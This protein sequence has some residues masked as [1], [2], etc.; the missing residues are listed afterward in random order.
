MDRDFTFSVYERLCTTLLENSFN[1]ITINDFIV[2]K[3][4]IKNAAIIR[5][6][7]DRKPN[8]ALKMARLENQLG[9]V[10]TYY[11]RTTKEVFIPEIISEISKLN[12]EIGYHYEVLALNNGNK[13]KAIKQ[14][15]EEL[16]LL[17]EI[18]KI[19]TIC[20]HGSPLSN[21][22]DSDMWDD[23]DYK[24]YANLF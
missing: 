5:H 16:E 8:Q 13:S 1:P 19:S 11:F 14:F 15:E 6:D 18:S 17:R 3:A 21:W 12:H 4:S 23:F 24:I 22:R 9:I 20:M 2:N 10:S 7:V